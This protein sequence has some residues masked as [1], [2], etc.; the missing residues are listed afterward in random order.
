MP[1]KNADRRVSAPLDSG[2]LAERLE[3]LEQELRRLNT[4]V[5]AP[6][7]LDGAIRELA[8]T[9]RRWREHLLQGV[10]GL[11][12]Y[13]AVNIQGTLYFFDTSD[14]KSARTLFVE[15]T[16]R[17]DQTHLRRALAVLE[18]A[19][20]EAMRDVFVDVG[21]HIGTTTLYA[22]RHLGFAEA[23][24]IEPELENMRLLRLSVLANGLE[25]VVHTVHAAASNENG[26]SGLDVGGVGSEYH[27]IPGHESDGELR[28]LVATTTLD[29]L[30]RDGV[31]DPGRVGLLWMDIEGY[32]LHALE[33]ASILLDSAPPIV[34]EMCRAKLERT[35]MLGRAPELLAPHYTH[36]LDLRKPIEDARFEPVSTIS[37]LIDAYDR[38]CVDVLICR[39]PK[40]S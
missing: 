7:M 26:V 12:P 15:N 32:E 22:V 29:A 4:K 20:V 31:L 30:V 8:K 38:H 27:H 25:N 33:G 37:D 19:G 3:A 21:A 36:I 6:D 14:A 5:R 34:A 28:Q 39:L 10:R 23:V 18:E 35:G 2:E 16:I 13:M 24:A 1:R 17:R 11:A 40:G 9:D